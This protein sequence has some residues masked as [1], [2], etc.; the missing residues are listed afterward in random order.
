[1]PKV[2]KISYYR[3]L[4][5]KKMQEWGRR[6]YKKC[7][8]CKKPHSCLHHY[9]PKS[10]SSALRYDPDNLI[11][12]CAGH[13]FRHHKGDP[14]I[15]NRVN[16]KKGARWLKKLEKKKEGYVKTNVKYYKSIIEEY[17]KENS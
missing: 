4:A 17:E 13:H 14:S 11:N 8:I 7:L 16:A 2:K 3:K 15:H 10:T 1:M 6:T 9:Y 5:D 12:I